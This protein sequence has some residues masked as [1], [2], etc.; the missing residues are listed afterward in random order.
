MIAFAPAFAAVTDTVRT[1]VA[2]TKLSSA[3]FICATRSSTSS[4]AVMGASLGAEVAL[5]L[6]VREHAVLPSPLRGGVGGGG[7][8]IQLVVRYLPPQPSPGSGGGSAFP[9]RLQ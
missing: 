4:T 7:P 5:S 3:A 2:S 1:S 8:R 6:S 9:T